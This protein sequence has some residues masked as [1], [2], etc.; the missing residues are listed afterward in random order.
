MH[1]EPNKE[2]PS[3][4]FSKKERGHFGGNPDRFQFLNLFFGIKQSDQNTRSDHEGCSN[5]CAPTAFLAKESDA[6]DHARDR[7]KGTEDSGTLTADE[8]RSALKQNNGT[9]VADQSKQNT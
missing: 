7:L 3:F 8:T 2:K 6:C 5:D 4:L 1:K 9:H